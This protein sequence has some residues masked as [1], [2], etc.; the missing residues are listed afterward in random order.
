MYEKW[1]KNT[2]SGKNVSVGLQLYPV[3][4]DGVYVM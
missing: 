4:L 2:A 3:A 1:K